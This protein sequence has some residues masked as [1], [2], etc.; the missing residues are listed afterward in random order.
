LDAQHALELVQCPNSL[1]GTPGS[2]KN[3]QDELD[4]LAQ[5]CLDKVESFIQT[6]G[7]FE[8]A[9]F[10]KRARLLAAQKGRRER[11]KVCL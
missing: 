6:V 9:I 4:L 7:R 11:D 10:Q 8:D 5:V 1:V 3:Q 2:Y